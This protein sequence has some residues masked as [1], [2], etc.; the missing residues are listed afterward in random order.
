[1]V[2]VRSLL[3]G[4]SRGLALAD[5]MTGNVG[6]FIQSNP[7]YNYTRQQYI[8]IYAQD[9]WKIKPNLT[10]SYGLR[11]EPFLATTVKDKLVSHFDIGAFTA[12]THSAVYP[13]APAG[14][15][16]PGDAGFPD[17][18]GYFSKL[19]LFAPRLG[20]RLEPRG[21]QRTYGPRFLRNLL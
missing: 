13:G 2:R 6:T 19:N 20:H 1:M 17:N 3:A 18:S 14:V 5:F 10:L 7:S 15:T 9:S 8:G 12:N 16:Y 4:S 21:H 11:W